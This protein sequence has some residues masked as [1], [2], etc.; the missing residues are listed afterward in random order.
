M[1]ALFWLIMLLCSS[2]SAIHLFWSPTLEA[3]IAY[4]SPVP[5]IMWFILFLV[6]TFT[7]YFS[8]MRFI[9]EARQP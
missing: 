9:Q 4:D 2:I 7:A 1:K 5:L 3:A 6:L 8:L